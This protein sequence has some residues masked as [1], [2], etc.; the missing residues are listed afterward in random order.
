MGT[1]KRK[2]W[3]G[4][5]SIPPLCGQ[6]FTKELLYRRSVRVYLSSLDT[7]RTTIEKETHN[8]IIICNLGLMLLH[9]LYDMIHMIVMQIM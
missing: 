7:I 2:I 3:I 6:L 9:V 4:V 5:K 8:A 1:V